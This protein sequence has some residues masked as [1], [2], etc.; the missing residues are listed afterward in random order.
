MI[1]K[2][3]SALFIS[4]IILCIS[5]C[6][7]NNNL[8]EEVGIIPIRVNKRIARVDNVITNDT[9]KIIDG[10][11]N[12]SVSF[13]SMAVEGKTMTSPEKYFRLKIE[14]NKIIVERIYLNNALITAYYILYD[15]KGQHKTFVAEN[16]D[17]LG[18]HDFDD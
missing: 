14:N 1:M 13:K 15:D 10:N 12:Y 2:P 11:G 7:D 4:L 8:N 17:I 18:L 3:I 9:I 16:P 5:S 6:S